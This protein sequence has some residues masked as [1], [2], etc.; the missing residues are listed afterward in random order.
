VSRPGLKP[1]R[2]TVTKPDGATWRVVFYADR[3][4]TAKRY[5]ADWAMKHGVTVEILEEA[6]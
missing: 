2:F 4:A 6:A 3:L 5:A 1:F